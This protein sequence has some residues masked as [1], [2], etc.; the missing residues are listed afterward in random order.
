M[1]QTFHWLTLSLLVA[2]SAKAQETTPSDAPAATEG[3]SQSST[4]M[5][6]YRKFGLGLGSGVTT[7]ITG[8]YFLN[9]GLAIQANL[10]LYF[11]FSTIIGADAM[12]QGKQLW[13]NGDFGLNWEAGAG[14]SLWV[15]NAGLYGFGSLAVNGVIG[16]SLQY[17]K[18]PLELTADIRP[19]FV[20]G[21][22]TAFSPFQINGGGALRYYF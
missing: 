22:F 7:G 20:F 4:N 1:R 15:W 12:Y 19:T 18:I 9:E 17:K 6:A 14:A 21:T 3:E 8:K 2:A 10:G 11:G 16:L 5:H 13:T